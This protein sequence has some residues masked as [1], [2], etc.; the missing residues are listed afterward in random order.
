M[1]T[2]DLLD[3]WIHVVLMFL[4][5][6]WNVFSYWEVIHAT[7]FPWVYKRSH[8]FPSSLSGKCSRQRLAVGSEFLWVKYP[9]FISLL[10]F[11]PRRCLSKENVA[12][13]SKEVCAS[14]VVMVVML[15]TPCSEVECKTTGYPLH[16]HVSP[17]LPLPCVTVCHQVS[18]EL[19]HTVR[20]MEDGC[21]LKHIK[22][23]QSVAVATFIFQ[24]L[25][26]RGCTV[27]TDTDCVGCWVGPISRLDALKKVFRPGFEAPCL[28]HFYRSEI[29]LRID[30]H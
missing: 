24:P 6:V 22:P 3:F 23:W 29:A 8:I 17:S 30:I 14:A 12:S 10:S 19:Y 27:H 15:D 16:S 7:Y 21:V 26:L 28:H 1:K 20:H 18:T 4:R 11:S 9:W 13:L 5:F 25:Y 2:H